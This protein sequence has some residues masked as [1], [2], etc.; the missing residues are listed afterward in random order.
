MSPEPK[1]VSAEI[2]EESIGSLR[3]CL[4][5]G[6]TEQRRGARR[7]HRRALAISI[8]LQSAVL[9]TLFLV[10]LLGK[11]ERNVS[12]HSDASRQRQRPNLCRFCQPPRIP[13][14][15]VTHDPA[16]IET[17]EAPI[18]GFEPNIPG[19][20]DGPIP[21]S[22]PRQRGP[23]NPQIET[24][25]NL[26]RILHITHLDPAMLQH[27]VEPEYPAIA[28]QT[29]C[30]GRVELRA[31]IG[32]DGSIQSVQV[33]S[34]DPLFLRSALDA[35]QH[36]TTNRHTSMAWLWK[37][38]PTSPS[39]TPYSTNAAIAHPHRECKRCEGPALP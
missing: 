25:A 36:G 4:V 21:L 27:R 26:P 14:T 3:S 37:W 7:V 32:T 2:L 16:A 28:K 29:R 38:I 10:P 22:D 13:H 30:E 9:A 12:H 1:K 5:E 20:P 15:I 33:V 17:A 39:C 11:A 35:V 23:V 31:T 24:R 8:L 34:G 6:D 18:E 19:A